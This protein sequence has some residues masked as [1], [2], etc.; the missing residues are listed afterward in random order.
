VKATRKRIVRV[1]LYVILIP[2]GLVLLYVLSSGP[3]AAWVANTVSGQPASS[4]NPAVYDSRLRWYLGFYGRLSFVRSWLRFRV[5]GEAEAVF[6]HYENLFCRSPRL[7]DG[8]IVYTLVAPEE[9]RL[10][11]EQLAEWFRGAAAA[12]LVQLHPDTCIYP[13][14]RTARVLVVLAHENT[15]DRYSL[16]WTVDDSVV[17]FAALTLPP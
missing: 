5:S 2:A 9:S 3:A 15:A 4:V 10:S 14:P 1:G 11:Q 13:W 17:G 6:Q 16:D 7:A 8:R 12:S